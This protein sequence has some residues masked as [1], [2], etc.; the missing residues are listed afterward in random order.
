MDYLRAK[1]PIALDL[2]IPSN[3]RGAFRPGLLASRYYTTH[4]P[5]IRTGVA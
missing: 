5:A 1:R 4:Y 2:P 3:Q